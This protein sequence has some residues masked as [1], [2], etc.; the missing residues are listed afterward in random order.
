M[1]K[2][3]SFSKKATMVME[4][5]NVVGKLEDVG[6]MRVVKKYIGKNCHIKEKYTHTNIWT[7]IQ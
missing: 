3:G 5:V 1:V 4:A 7:Q 6:G 2:R